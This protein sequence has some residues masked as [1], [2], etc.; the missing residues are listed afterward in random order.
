MIEE[1]K[2]ASFLICITALGFTY[3][4]N[5]S[6][7][8][9]AIA[10]S[11]SWLIV[12]GMY[13]FFPHDLYPI[14]SNL[15]NSVSLWVVG[16]TISCSVFGRIKISNSA[17]YNQMLN[18]Q[19][20]KLILV[21]TTILN[22]IGFLAYLKLGNGGIAYNILA[23]IAR[24]ER[25]LPLHIKILQYV[26]ALSILTFT[27]IILYKDKLHVNIHI[28]RLF[29]LSLVLWILIAAD[30]TAIVQLCL[31]IFCKLYISKSK[32]L[33][34]A[35]IGFI[36]IFLLLILVQNARATSNQKHEGITD[37]VTTYV[38]SSLP[39]YDA[40]T[41][42]EKNFSKGKTTRFITQV[43]SKTKIVSPPHEKETGW[44]QVPIYTNVY[45]V[46]F[47]AY[48]DFGMCGVFFMALIQG[49]LWIL[50]YNEM[51]AHSYLW[52]IFFVNFFYSLPLEFF[53]DYLTNYTSLFIQAFLIIW[54][55][56]SKKFSKTN[57]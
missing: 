22:I 40:V 50:V 49:C 36:C 28:F 18:I 7:I 8:H 5:S 30:K 54:I 48:V 16:F 47:P 55:L 13:E 25:E 1:T 9:P 14:S 41:H 33:R 52:T 46:F 35:F 4:K 6:L 32:Y 39:A 15:Y 19:Y 20:I 10:V 45:T 2:I 27:I 42:D 53:S 31:I 37:I 34:Y 29:I 12:L 51:K 43:L 21:I 38:L 23:D 26:R 44:I 24:G 57:I 11:G 17:R 56:T 3:Y